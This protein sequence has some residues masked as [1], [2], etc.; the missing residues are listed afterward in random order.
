MSTLNR[1]GR[2]QPKCQYQLVGNFYVYSH[3]KILQKYYQLPI[4]SALDTS[5]HAHQKQ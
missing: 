3:E 4:L 5:D 2:R 1:S